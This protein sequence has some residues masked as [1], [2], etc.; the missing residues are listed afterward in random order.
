MKFILPPIFQFPSDKTPQ[1][2]NRVRHMYSFVPHSHAISILLMFSLWLK[3]SSKYSLIASFILRA[4]YKFIHPH[5]PFVWV[6]NLFAHHTHRRRRTIL[7]FVVLMA[8]LVWV[9]ISSAPFFF[10]WRLNISEIWLFNLI[11]L[12]F[13][14]L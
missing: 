9:L 11:L 10:N 6:T 1:D 13:F 14:Y 8:L 4:W 7:I 2:R 5:Y 3:M 12:A